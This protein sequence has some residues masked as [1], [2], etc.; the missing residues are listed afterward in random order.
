MLTG[1]SQTLQGT[2]TS[3]G[4]QNEQQRRDDDDDEAAA[5]DIVPAAVLAQKIPIRIH[6]PHN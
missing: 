5:D 4:E 3:S 6:F 2:Q 1:K